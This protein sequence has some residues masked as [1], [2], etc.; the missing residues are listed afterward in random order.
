VKSCSVRFRT[1]LGLPSTSDTASTAVVTP[2]HF[3]ATSSRGL[4]QPAVKCRGREY[5]RIIYGP[6]YTVPCIPAGAVPPAEAAAGLAHRR[7][8]HA[9]DISHTRPAIAKD[10][11]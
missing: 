7:A 3:V 5:L 4:Q 1:I 9:P 11:P 8:R 10:R 2:M 6:E